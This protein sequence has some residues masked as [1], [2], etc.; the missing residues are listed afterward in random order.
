MPITGG[1]FCFGRCRTELKSRPLRRIRCNLACQYDLEVHDDAGDTVQRGREFVGGVEWMPTDPWLEPDGGVLGLW[2]DLSGFDISADT[3]ADGGP[4][5]GRS[6][7]Q[8]GAGRLGTH[9]GCRSPEVRLALGGVV[10]ELKSWRLRRIRCNLACQYDLE[11]HDDAGDT[12]QRGWECV[13]GVEWMP[14]DPWLEPDGGVLGL[15]RDLSGFDISA[16]CG[17]RRAHRRQTTTQT[18]AGRL[19]THRGCRSVE[20]RLALGG[21]VL[22]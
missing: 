8:T 3:A 13:G 4:T 7:T 16:D 14:T 12:V 22:G 6:S 17:R 11:V 21:V 15:W 1:S 20:A 2:R 9:R 19:G 18:G 10:L 5:V